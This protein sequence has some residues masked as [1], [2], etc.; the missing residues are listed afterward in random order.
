[1]ATLLEKK[2]GSNFYSLLKTDGSGW[3]AVYIKAGAC[4]NPATPESF[5]VYER[6]DGSLGNDNQVYMNGLDVFNFTMR[7]VPKSIKEIT[8]KFNFELKDIDKIVFHQANKFMT[9]FFIKKLKYPKEKVPYCL[10]R[11]GNT[12]SASIPLTIVSELKN[13]HEE[14][15][16]ILIS[17]FGGGLS[18]GSAILDLKD[19]Y[20]SDLIEM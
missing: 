8:E 6:E 5:L 10:D 20:I 19:T 18:W 12:S 3:N 11:F 13:W 17:G 14:R 7:V 9:D 4:R 2:E 16:N 15:K 1:T